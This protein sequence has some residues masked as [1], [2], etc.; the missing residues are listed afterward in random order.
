MKE[1]NVS[2]AYA[3]AI[4]ELAKEAKVDVADELTRLNEVINKNNDLETVF[5][6][7]V[8]TVE[9][10]LAVAKDL[11]A[12]LNLS[13]V[14]NNFVS[15]LI[16]EKRLEIFPLIY[17]EIIVI[18]DHEKGFLR[19]TIEGSGE[20]VSDEFKFKMVS[21]LKEKAGIEAEL[22]YKQNDKITAGYRVT[23]EDLQLDA[24][25]DNQLEIF[26]ESVL[27]N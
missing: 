22:E 9:E 26:K 24:S 4:I 7:D 27:N 19:G 18:D 11:L 6:L 10:K 20:T 14:V 25:L 5:F 17:K 21:Y 1:Q 23:V 8:F 3:K 12:K 2:K 13:S 15:F 16:M